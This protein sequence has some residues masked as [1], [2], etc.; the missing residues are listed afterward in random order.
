M[1]SDPQPFYFGAATSAHQVEGNNFRSDWWKFEQEV[2]KGGNRQ[3]GRAVNH[4]ELFDQD[5][6]LA[7]ELGHNAHRFSIEWAKVEPVEG[8][9]DEQVL[10]HYRQVFASLKKHKLKPF[11]TLWHFSLP[12]WFAQKGGFEKRENI[13]YFVR[14][15][16]KIGETFK[17]EME[18][19]MTI[20]EPMIYLYYAYLLGTWPPQKKRF[21]SCVKV[22]TNMYRAH[23]AVYESLKRINPDFKIGIANNS[24]AFSPDRPGN[25]F[26]WILVHLLRYLC[27]HIFLDRICHHQDFIGLNYYSHRIMRFDWKLRKQ[28]FFRHCNSCD[29]TDMGW[30]VC[31]RAI[32]GVITD[33]WKRY[34]KPVFI[35]E[36]GVADKNDRLRGKF[37]KQTL[38]HVFNAKKNGAHVMG[39]LYWSLLDNFEWADGFEPRFGLV[40]IDYK[41]LARKPRP[42]AYEYRQLIH[43]YLKGLTKK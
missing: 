34:R 2:Q 1:P 10:D 32:S 37:I 27:N 24:L 40:E 13:Q 30:E 7:R 17:N 19:I 31:P 15:C 9:F 20:N 33:I 16:N 3:S 23:R 6:A 4:Y 39:Y 42:S 22:F 43:D 35:T 11:V 25:G 38:E 12:L 14:Y 8:V 41:N 5:F 28:F 29:L 18:F 36:N 26:D 21:S